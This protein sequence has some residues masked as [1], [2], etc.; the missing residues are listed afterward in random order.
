MLKENIRIYALTFCTIGAFKY[1][2]EGL[3]FDQHV[4]SIMKLDFFYERMIVIIFN[5]LA[6]TSIITLFRDEVGEIH[7]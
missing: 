1:A 2:L 3:F 6:I 4:N 7:R 5:L